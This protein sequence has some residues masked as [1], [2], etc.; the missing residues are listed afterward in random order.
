MI[1]QPTVIRKRN[2]KRCSQKAQRT[3]S[4][5]KRKKTQQ[6]VEDGARMLDRKDELL[7]T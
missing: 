1:F 3:T 7:Q 5:Q 4:A 6:E 2:R